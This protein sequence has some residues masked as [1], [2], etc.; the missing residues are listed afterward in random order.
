MLSLLAFRTPMQAV[1]SSL[2]T[3]MSSCPSHLA[4]TAGSGAQVVAVGCENGSLQL[5]D[6]R[7][8][9]VMDIVKEAH[10]SRIRG[11]AAVPEQGEDAMSHLL[12]SVSTD[13]AVK[14]WDLRSTGSHLGLC[15]LT[16]QQ[17]CLP[18]ELQFCIHQQAA[19]TSNP[20]PVR[21]ENTV[22]SIS[23]LEHD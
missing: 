2:H 5:L 15:F 23:C 19:W 4:M 21:A 16:F 17:R 11:L 20:M 6:T 10:S 9:T 18:H 7:S 12:G 22:S 1:P 14:L 13:G 3:V 8:G